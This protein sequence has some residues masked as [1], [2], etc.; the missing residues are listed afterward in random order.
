MVHGLRFRRSQPRLER[1]QL[2]GGEAFR[3]RQ[4][5]VPRDRKGSG[6]LATA[7]RCL[8]ARDATW[9]VEAQQLRRLV[10]IARRFFKS[11]AVNEVQ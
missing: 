1:L 10:Q 6:N 3:F 9:G 4:A 11:R 5:V 8:M 2:T 7:A